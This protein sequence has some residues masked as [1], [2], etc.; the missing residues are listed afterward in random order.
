M[1]F[2]QLLGISSALYYH[3]FP[4]IA[5]TGNKILSQ[6]HKINHVSPRDKTEGFAA[7]LSKCEKEMMSQKNDFKFLDSHPRLNDADYHL[8]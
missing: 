3:C 7:V 2:D 4:T 1:K 8:Q 5:V 6:D